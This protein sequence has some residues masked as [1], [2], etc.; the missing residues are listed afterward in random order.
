MLRASTILALLLTGSSTFAEDKP[1]LWSMAPPR[2]HQPPTIKN[3]EA[4]TAIDAFLLARLEKAG[5]SYRRPADKATLLRRVTF[6]LTGLPPTPREIDAFLKDDSADAYEKVVDRLLASPR[7]GERAALFWLDVVRFAETDGF[8][9][10]DKRSNAWR[11]RDYVIKSLNEDKPFDRFIKEQIAG[12]EFWP[13]DADALTATGFLRHYPDEYNAVNLEQRRQEILND[14]TDTV[15]QTFL[16]M[17]L[18]C[19]KCHDHKFDPIKQDDYYRMQAFF[20]GWK[21]VDTP[22]APAKQLADYR[23]QLAEW[24]AKTAEVRKEIAEIE[25]PYRIRF[26]QKQRSRFPDE[27]ARLLDVPD[28]KRSPLEKQI[29]T[30]IEKQVYSD[31]KTMLTGMKAPEKDRYDELKKRLEAIGPKPVEP[32]LTMAMTDVGVDVPGTFLLKRGDW[33]KREDEIKPGFLSAI[34]DRLAEVKAPA[35]GKTTGRRT[36]LAEWLTKPDH[37]LTS[38]VIVNRLWQQHFGKGIV[39][40]PGDFGRQG[41]KPTHPE[42]L[43]WLALELAKNG[44]KLK[45][46]HR[47]MVLSSAYQQSSTYDANAARVDE[48]NKLLWRMNRRRL[49]GETIRDAILTASGQINFKMHGPSIYPELPAELKQGGWTVSPEPERNRRSIYVY[50]KR[51]LRYPLFTAFDSPDRCE[52]CSKRFVTTTAPQALMLLNEK[53]IVDQAAV[54]ANRVVKEAGDKPDAIID[55]A[56]RIALGRVPNSEERV[57]LRNFL[58]R[59][60]AKG[61]AKQAVVDLCHSLLNVN[62][63]VYVD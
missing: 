29:G 44:W 2:L 19:A 63:F 49:E 6:D 59:Q 34:D 57:A 26:S 3:A 22:V 28:E 31:T 51:N 9:A 35:S 11:Y 12:D 46:L 37:P 1:A 13:D 50:V 36:A 43:D 8:K 61:D 42:L 41:D 4:A 15:G 7:F 32:P 60:T 54:F 33:R 24:E 23:K 55:S 62:E 40:T 25:K 10:D 16:G 27:Y 30:M 48:E 47:L 52:T 53:L 20:A 58:Q 18:G 56:Y 5:L 45:P 39:A 14:I 38:R 21:P 17:T